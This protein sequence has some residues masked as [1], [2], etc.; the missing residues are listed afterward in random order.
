[1]STYSVKIRES[2]GAFKGTTE[3]YR[4]AVDFF[5]VVAINEW[6]KISPIK[7][8]QL[9][10]REVELLTHQTEQKSKDKI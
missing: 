4:Q 6:E 7:S 8:S 10:Q 2:H 5:I 9:R 1:M 3:E